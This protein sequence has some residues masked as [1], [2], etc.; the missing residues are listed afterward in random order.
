MVDGFMVFRVGHRRNSHA[1]QLGVEIHDIAHVNIG[2]ASDACLVLVV[3]ADRNEM[4]VP[5]ACRS[6]T[7]RKP[8]R[9]L[10]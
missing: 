3:N 8:R 4:Q 7:K 2:T 9:P 5:H 6:G 10:S 1:R